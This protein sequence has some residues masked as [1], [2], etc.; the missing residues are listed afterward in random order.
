MHQFQINCGQLNKISFSVLVW[1][2][3][4]KYILKIN[5]NNDFFYNLNLK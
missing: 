1:I 4:S 2:G 5:F 3:D